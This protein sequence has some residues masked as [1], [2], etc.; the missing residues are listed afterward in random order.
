LCFIVSQKVY[1]D[2]VINEVMANALDEDTGEFIE[3]YNTGEE[4]VDVVG[5]KFTD[6]DAT[7]IIQPF[8]KGDKGIIPP[9]SYGVI[10]DSEYA[11][12]YQIPDAAVLLTTK[13]TTLGNGLTTNDPITLFDE[14]GKVL[15]TYSHPFNP[16]NGISAEKLDSLEG[17]EPDN[18]KESRDLSGSTPG[19]ENSH[20]NPPPEPIRRLVII[21]PENV[22]E[23]V[24]E[25][26]RI[27]VQANGEKDVHW[28]GEV[29]IEAN[30]ESVTLAL[31]SGKPAGNSLTLKLENGSAEFHLTSTAKVT[32]QLVAQSVSDSNLKSAK[33]ITVATK[34]VPWFADVIINE[35][36]HSPDTKAGQ[37]EWIEIYNRSSQ[38]ADLSGW[39][40][41]DERNKPVSISVGT[42]I[43]PNQFLILTKDLQKFLISFPEVKN[44]V[45]IKIPA[46]NNTGDTVILRNPAGQ[47]IDEVKYESTSSIHSRSLE[48]LDP[49]RPSADIANWKLT[50]DLKGGTPGCV[51]SISALISPSKLDLQITPNPFNPQISPTQI[52]YRAPKDTQVTIKIFDSAG[53]LV[54]T[55]LEKREAGGEQIIS[56]NGKDD[57]GKRVSVGLYICQIIT[58][59]GK[60]KTSQRATATIVVAKR[61]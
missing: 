24:R 37:V 44:V 15:D 19:K 16:G 12:E 14:T 39:S 7:D 36:M 4:P 23:N 11:E 42:I 29:K 26:F 61:L 54:R 53:K 30:V 1:A 59:G 6:G 50:I 47:K 38:P 41:S 32:I 55:L 46:L 57:A 27:E 28:E 34:P 52:K 58:A 33:T 25:T 3:L 45:E 56:W 40:I 49:N 35:I 10:L 17:D 13:N 8:R 51:N 9:K 5:L 31:V 48:R 20:L 60:Q 22:R 18:W 21:G 43:P 2:I